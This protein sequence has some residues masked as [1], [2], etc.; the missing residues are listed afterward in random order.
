MFETVAKI[1]T[2]LQVGCIRAETAEAK[3]NIWFAN[4]SK[5]SNY[6]DCTCN[7]IQ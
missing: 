7:H 2:G 4:I 5:V 1:A 3:K 6:T